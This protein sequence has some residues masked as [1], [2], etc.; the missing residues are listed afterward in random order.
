MSEELQW[1]AVFEDFEQ[2]HQGDRLIEARIAFK[3]LLEIVE[4]N[5]WTD[6][7]NICRLTK[8]EIIDTETK[9]WYVKEI[10]NLCY[11]TR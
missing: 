4:E 1:G 3:R 8:P 9:Q 2:H 10:F 11:A 6:A 7:Y 5:K